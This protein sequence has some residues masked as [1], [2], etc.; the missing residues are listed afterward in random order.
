MISLFRKLNLPADYWEQYKAEAA[1]SLQQRWRRLSEGLLKDVQPDKIWVSIRTANR[2]RDR[3]DQT[4]SSAERGGRTPEPEG[5]DGWPESRLTLESFLQGCTGKVTVLA[6][7][8]GSGK[9][10]LMSFIGQQWTKGLGP[11][12]SSHLFVLLELRQLNLLSDP[13]SLSELLF[14]HYLPTNG[15]NEAKQ[16]VVDYLLSNPEQSCWVL[17]GYDEFQKKLKRHRVQ[18]ERLDSE[19]PRPVAELISGLLSRRLLAG[20]TV[21]VTSRVRDVVDLD[22]LSD[23]VGQLL[24]WDHRE[25]KE[26]VNNFFSGKDG[27]LAANAAEILFSSRHLLAMSSLPALCNIC[28][29]FLQHS[30]HRHAEKTKVPGEK[31]VGVKKKPLEIERKDAQTPDGMGGNE[32]RSQKAQHGENSEETLMDG[33]KSRSMFSFTSAQIPS[34]QTQIYLAAVVAF[35]NRHT[36]RTGGNNAAEISGFSQSKFVFVSLCSTKFAW[37]TVSLPAAELCELSRVAWRGLEESRIIFLDEDVPLQTLQSSVKS[38]LF[39]QMEVRGR[40]GGVVNA[41]CFLHLT[42][43]EFLAA[44]RIMTSSDVSD[45]DLKKKFSLKTRWTTKSD[46]KTVF[47]DSLYLYVCGLASSDCTPALEVVAKATGLKAAQ[48]WVQKRQALVLKLLEALCRS[49][50]LTGPKILQLCHCV[51]ESQNQQLAQ[52]VV[53]VRPTLELRNFWLLTSDIEALA[54]VVNSVGTKDV[55]LDF[56]ACSMELECLDILSRCQYIHYLSFRS[57]KYGDKFAEKLSSVLPRFIALRKLEFCGASLSSAGAASLASGLQNC[58]SVTELNFSDNNLQDEGIRHIADVLAKLQNLASVKLGRNNTSL[59]AAECLVKHVSSCSNI[60]QVHADGIKELTLTFSQK[61]ES[62]RLLNQKWT[63]S[64]MQNLARSLAR[65]PS[66]SELDLSGGEWDEETLKMLTQFVPNFSITDRIILN[67]SCSSVQSAVILTALLSDCLSVMEMNISLSC[68]NLQPIDLERVW[69]SLGASSDLSD[70]DL[71]CNKLGDKGLKKLLDFL[72]RLSKIQRVENKLLEFVFVFFRINRRSLTVSDVNK[73]CRKLVQCRTSL[74]LEFTQYFHIYTET[75][76]DFCSL[77]IK[78]DQSVSVSRLTDFSFKEE[79]FVLL[80]RLNQILQ[81]SRQLSYLDLSG[82]Q[83]E[84]EGVRCLLKSLP[85]IR[86]SSFIN[87]SKNGLSQQ[88]ALHV[89]TALCTCTNVSAVEVSLGEDERCL[90]WFRQKGGEKTLSVRDSRL[91]CDHLLRLANI[92]SDCLSLTKVDLSGV[93]ISDAAAQTLTRLL[94]R[95]RSFNSSH[96]VWSAAGRLQ[97]IETLK[98]SA[99]KKSEFIFIFRLGGWRMGDGGIQKLT[100]ILPGW[101]DLRTISLSK[102]LVSDP[103]GEKLLEALSENNL[104]ISTI[105]GLLSLSRAIMSLKNLR[106]IHLTSVRNSE[107]S[108]VAA[109]LSHCPFIQDVG[110]GWNNC[111]DDVALELAKVLPVC[112][113][114]TRIDLECNSVSAAGVEALVRALRCCPALQ[115]IRLWKNKVSPNEAYRFSQM[116]RR[117]KFSST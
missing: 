108:A 70:L 4:P 112:H 30:L 37:K 96:C 79:N 28:C 9:T 115:V 12:P 117:L 94:P 87:L 95:L 24:P 80:D 45:A 76:N 41:Y 26:C 58:P 43:Q 67:D 8:P 105:S 69:R 23:K 93:L 10:L 60:Q 49:A 68:C 73:V 110:F 88:G 31:A 21:L 103:S 89:A 32:S 14:H 106:K 27:N 65:C 13:L 17:D 7:Q 20:S 84:D 56:G 63:K 57:R 66:L 22:G 62:N 82:N 83:L 74:E 90:I 61:S 77:N 92:V 39:S 11:I 33:A 100:G 85:N 42:V 18:N 101:K 35:L 48:N 52:Q 29:V 98:D 34:T 91:Q 78:T 40:G 71:S 97:F 109:S 46:Q 44:L 47:T 6:G 99:G 16:A 1:G 55:G 59:E 51:Q 53:R 107:L 2:A 15:D 102:N 25:I 114:L 19:K 50:S 38:G 54:F 81:Q 113:D 36:D 75:K 111:G 3:P 5:D 116:E 86:V 64:G 72:P 104:R